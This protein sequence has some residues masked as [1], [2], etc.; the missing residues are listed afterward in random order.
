MYPPP[1]PQQQP[2]MRQSNKWMGCLVASLIA[3]FIIGILPGILVTIGFTSNQAFL[4]ILL[5]GGIA[6]FLWNQQR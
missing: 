5:A 2:R 6:I 4:G 1:P 3:I